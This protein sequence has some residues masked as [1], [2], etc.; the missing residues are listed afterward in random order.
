MHPKT[1]FMRIRVHIV[2]LSGLLL[3]GSLVSVYAADKQPGKGAVFFHKTANWIDNILLNG[4]DTAYVNL[5]EYRW[6]VALTTGETSVYSEFKSNDTYYFGD[7]TLRSLSRPSAELGFNAGYR[8]ISFGYS[9][10]VLRAHA[11]NLSF[12]AGS[13]MIGI[14]FMR[15]RSTGFRTELDMPKY[16][17]QPEDLG[18]FGVHLTHMNLSLWYALN[19]R[20]YSHNA[21]MKQAF[22]QKHTA[23]SPILTVS[24]SLTNIAFNDSL[25]L[26][27][28]LAYDISRLVT[29]QASVGLGY[30]INYTPNQGKFLLHADAVAKLAFYSINQVSFRGMDSISDFA[31]PAFEIRSKTPFHFSGSLRAALSWEINKWVHLSAWAMA[32]NV[33]FSAASEEADVHFSNW[34]WSAHINFGVRFGAGMHRTR[35]VLRPT[36]FDIPPAAN[37][38]PTGKPF[39]TWIT[40]YFYSPR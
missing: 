19:W 10:D 1:E 4:L 12:N 2:L 31:T 33:R 14:D 32:E 23:G 27:P 5:P 37:N 28:Q 25:D 8:A 30:G 9:W 24:Y 34:H 29:H 7:V 16:I 17:D 6:C 15:I 36:V 11:Q 40:D 26:L 22:L 39:P 18:E 21:A 38:A 35:E 20:R 3:V 13:K